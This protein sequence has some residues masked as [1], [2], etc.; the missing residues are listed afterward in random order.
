[1]SD[2]RPKGVEIE[3]GGQ[4]RTLLFTINAIDE[5]QEKCNMPLLDAMKYVAQAADGETDHDTVQNFRAIITVLLNDENSGS[6]TEKEVGRMI[7]IGNYSSVAWTVL[8]AYG[9][10]NP[11]PD[12]EDDEEDEEDEAPNVETGQ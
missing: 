10:S 7:D 12:E 1:M 3:I 4:K 6:L 9:I 2:L 11:D 8:N 5:I